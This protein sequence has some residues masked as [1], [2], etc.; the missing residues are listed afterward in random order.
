MNLADSL[1][2]VGIPVR[3]VYGREMGD[4]SG[5]T[6]DLSGNI[7]TIGVESRG[8]LFELPSSRI[9]SA[10]KKEV[11][12]FPDWK[13]E[14]SASGFETDVLE[15]KWKS[16]AKM[17]ESG[18]INRKVYEEMSERFVGP[19]ERL[20]ALLQKID[21]RLDE[22]QHHDDE[23]DLFL[24]KVRLQS[25]DPLSTAPSYGAVRERC[26]AMK[27]TNE[28]ERKDLRS[29]QDLIERFFAPRDERAPAE[30]HEEEPNVSGGREDQQQTK[31]RE[32]YE[33]APEEGVPQAYVS[34]KSLA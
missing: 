16:L 31:E 14:A 11:V 15:A 19:R 5:Y 12:I 3:D 4:F 21:G 8:S 26:E 34:L 28:S 1:A 24:T 22:L 6:L 29:V 17:L 18:E 2:T 27:S 33:E 20:E 10:K 32:A 9:A 23:I 7:M 25:E 30:Q 13:A